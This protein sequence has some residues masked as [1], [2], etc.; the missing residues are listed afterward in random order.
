MTRPSPSLW[1][2]AAVAVGGAMGALLRWVLEEAFTAPADGFP[3]TT[4]AIN[5][6]GSGLLALLPGVAPVRARPALGAL[7]GPGFLGGFTTLSTYSEETRALLD[8]G[9]LAVAAAYA[10]GTL[11]GCLLAVLLADRLARPTGEEAA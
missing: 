11:A 10:L 1:L 8:S 3:W 7:L 4:F 6:I 2:V 9:H 5:V